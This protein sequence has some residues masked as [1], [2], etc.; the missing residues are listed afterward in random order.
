MEVA[1]SREE[2]RSDD[3]G[4][5][6]LG[7]DGGE[8]GARRGHETDGESERR[9]AETEERSTRDDFIASEGREGGRGG[10]KP[11]AEFSGS[12]D[13]PATI[14]GRKSDESEGE[15]EGKTGETGEG[16][17]G[18]DSPSL[19]RAGKAGCGG[20][21]GGGGARARARRRARREEG[22]DRWVPPVSESGGRAR[23]SAAR[24]RGGADGPR[25]KRERGRD[26]AEPAQERKGG[27]EDFF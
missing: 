6:E 26:W 4:E 23:L 5:T 11:A 20:I 27:K 24:A 13:A 10:R 1:P 8:R 3:G 2:D 22:D 14:T 17:T 7:G 21:R 12:I 16:I 15:R 18:N 25:G 19:R 9:A